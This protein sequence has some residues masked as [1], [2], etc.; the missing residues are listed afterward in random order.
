[1]YKKDLEYEISDGFFVDTTKL[2]EIILK[3]I[4]RDGGLPLNNIRHIQFPNH[5]DT[6]SHIIYEFPLNWDGKEKIQAKLFSDCQDIVDAVEPIIQAAEKYHN[7]TR[8]RILIANLLAGKIIT[9][10]NDQGVYLQ[11]IQRNHIPV[12]TNES[13]TF[14]VGNKTINMKENHLYH[15]N[16]HKIHAIN[17]FGNTDRYHLI[18]DIFKNDPLE[19]ELEQKEIYCPS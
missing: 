16:N 4:E 9:P 10:H 11:T 17:N 5:G 1:M 12:L 13:A 8:A 14:T 15:I 6:R 18:V 3:Y 2:K 19:Y 7:G